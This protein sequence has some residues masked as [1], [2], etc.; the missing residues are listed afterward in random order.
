MIINGQELHKIRR[1]RST[2]F[3]EDVSLPVSSYLKAETMNSA[4]A[5]IKENKFHNFEEVT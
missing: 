1:K 4:L 2:R 3:G 5:G